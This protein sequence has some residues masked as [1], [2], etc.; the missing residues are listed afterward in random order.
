LL[1]RDNERAVIAAARSACVLISG[2]AGIG[3]TALL[4]DHE[5]DTPVLRARGSELE[6]SFAFGGVQ[7]LFARVKVPDEGEA[8]HA[9]AAFSAHGE[10]NHAVLHGLYWLTVSQG[11]LTLVVD[12][13]H[14]LDRQTL[15]WLT[16]MVNRVAELPLTIL[17]AA[18]SD[19]PDEL[20]T[21]I[22]LHPSTTTLTP[23]PL[24]EDAVRELAGDRAAELHQATG[25]NPFYVHALLADPD[26][27]P[28]PVIE[29]IALR[30]DALPP[31]CARLARA[32]A[33]AGS[34]GTIAARLAQLDVR[35]AVEAAEA[36]AH[37][38]LLRGDGFAHP[39]VQHAVYDAIPAAE[40]AEL[41]AAAARLVDGPERIAAHVMAAGPGGGAWAAN[42]LRAAANAA[43]ARGAPDVAARFLKRAAEEE[44]P[45][46]DLVPVLRELARAQI[47]TGGPE[48]FPVLRQALAIAAPDERHEIARELGQALLVQGYFSEAAAVF[49]Q[50][51]AHAELATTAVLDLQLV[52]RFGGLDGLLARAPG[53]SGVAA[54]ITV[55]TR[56]PASAGADAA[57]AALPT[58]TPTEFPGV[59]IA[60]MGAGRLE[61]A[62]ATW[63][64]AAD[65]A[66]ARGELETLRLAVALRAQ[67]RMRQG[68]VAEVEADLRELI[69]W[70]SEL[71][72]PYSDL[73]MALPWIVAPLV[74]ALVER[75]ELDEAEHWVTVTD[76]AAN[77]PEV[78]G[79][80]FL[81]D[82]LARL[83]LAQG[84][85]AEAL[86]LARE[87][88]RRQR[89]WGIRNP[90]FLP[91]GSTLAA[92]LHATGRTT[93]A[94]D[95]CDQQIDLARA[96]E[97][98]R[99]LGMGLLTLATITGETA[100]AREAEHVL[101]GS[102]ARL[103]HARALV[104]VGGRDAL[105][106]ALEIAERC[107]ATALAAR[108]RDDLVA[109]GAR[110]RRARLTDLTA[111]QER[112]A[113]LAAGGL[114][115]RQI[116]ETLWVTE[117]TVEGHLGA[118]YRKLGIGSRAQLGEALRTI[119]DGVA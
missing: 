64:G 26:T 75:G 80:T 67:I 73:R 24:S 43:W 98:P 107:G 109:T 105:R 25:G 40:R 78:F 113:R 83:R 32:I 72:L 23:R 5:P 91:W 103:E 92:A 51:G 86:G 100:T 62:D 106:E 35:Q 87:T 1:E 74:D 70:V 19:E 3:K 9:R 55:A 90:G 59:L 118:A 82:S 85:V 18:R 29:S 57:E 110:P 77:W 66:R 52:R 111:A 95:V 56:P 47:A 84:R 37:A 117:K 88:G 63:T 34:G 8:A 94:V 116:A 119:P 93:E 49:E 69:A 27:T 108:A 115:N 102:P 68:R 50:A 6:R 81:L 2:P 96:F 48:G 76:L 12:D 4:E 89:A 7:Q 61:Q 16:Y 41:H 17:L 28:K 15:R 36:L 33:V 99:E 30:L 101:R 39:L 13:A 53:P 97:V 54:W 21:R 14:W 114:G 112:V 46:D 11:P 65:A 44:L 20:L 42:A 22:A 58:A 45:R 10:P 71:E 31:D 38:D 79:F 60:L 104:A